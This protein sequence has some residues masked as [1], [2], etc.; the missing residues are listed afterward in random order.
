[1]KNI[2][3]FVFFCT[4]SLGIC[5]KELSGISAQQII[6]G[7]SFIRTN[8]NTGFP[9]YILFQEEILQLHLSKENISKQA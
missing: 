9:D 2:I 4:F 7:A 1:M 8:E 5:A 6:S 3:V